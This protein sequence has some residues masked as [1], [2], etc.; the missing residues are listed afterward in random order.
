MPLHA[1][2]NT[3]PYVSRPSRQRCHVGRHFLDCRSLDW[4]QH[5]QSP[6]EEC[7]CTPSPT[8]LTTRGALS[9]SQQPRMAGR[10]NCRPWWRAADDSSGRTSPSVF[11]AALLPTT[12]QYALSKL[13]V[14][15]PA[16]DLRYTASILPAG[17]DRAACLRSGSCPSCSLLTLLPEGKTSPLAVTLKWP[18]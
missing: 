16:V 11:P 1:H 17:V 14:A 3:T 2:S 15:H 8:Q 18:T 4:Q 10:P 9:L 13:G 5:R 7:D 12:L 6:A